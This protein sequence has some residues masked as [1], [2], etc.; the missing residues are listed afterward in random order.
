MLRRLLRVVLVPLL[1]FA[2]P[3]AASEIPADPGALA[4]LIERH[5]IVLLGEVHD[6][7]GQ[8]ALRAKALANALANG[9]RPALAFEQF[10]VD[11]QPDIERARREKPGDA[12][13]LIGE[14][15]GRGN[16][17]WT[18]YRPFI[19]L[20]LQYDLPIVAAN[21]S[22]S[23]AGEVASAGWEAVFDAPTQQALGLEALPSEFL[24]RHASAIQRG[25]CNALPFE[26]IPAMARAQ[27]AR[28]ITMARALE[29]HAGRG[30]VLLAGN[31]HVRNDIGVPFWLAAQDRR[32]TIAV[33][34]VEREGESTAEAD[35]H[36][37]AW[38]I[39]AAAKREDP[40]MKLG[41][42]RR[43]GKPAAEES[44]RD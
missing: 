32:D 27:I 10:D 35:L 38:F 33:G 21:L 8:H 40:C 29:P 37:D 16:W 19:V 2:G 15:R 25:H 3:A 12:D 5:R 18:F 1:C 17:N 23:R 34:A 13:H 28:D 14:A 20:A 41:P 22:R 4:R 6:N 24:G 43:L 31:G 26:V 39:T 44:P 42:L 9:R 11:R 7:A 30:V 36:Y